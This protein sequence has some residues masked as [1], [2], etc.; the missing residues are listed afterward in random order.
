[1]PHYKDTTNNVHY[2]DSSVFEYLLPAGSVQITDEEADEL[3]TVSVEELPQ[4]DPVKKLKDFLDANP[5]VK[6]MI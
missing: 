3:R 2:L 4:I 6:A 5:D 1:M